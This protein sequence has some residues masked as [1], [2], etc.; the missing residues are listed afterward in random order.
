MLHLLPGSTWNYHWYS[1]IIYFNEFLIT[2]ISYQLDF[3]RSYFPYLLRKAFCCPV[4]KL[5][6]LPECSTAQNESAAEFFNKSTFLVQINVNLPLNFFTSFGTLSPRVFRWKKIKSQT[7]KHK[8]KK[9]MPFI[10]LGDP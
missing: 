8:F 7:N 4:T 5:Q 2:G 9:P 10:H 3:Q 6:A 1:E